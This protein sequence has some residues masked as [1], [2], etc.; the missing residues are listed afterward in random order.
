MINSFDDVAKDLLGAFQKYRNG[1]LCRK[2]GEPIKFV[3]D[4]DV[5]QALYDSLEKRLEANQ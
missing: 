1:Y 2:R 5:A 3:T 4:E